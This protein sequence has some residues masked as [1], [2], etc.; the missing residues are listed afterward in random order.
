MSYYSLL[1]LIRDPFVATPDPDLFYRCPHQIENLERLEICIRLR[2]GLN[3]VLGPVGTGKSTLSRHFMRILADSPEFTTVLM[4]DPLFENEREFLTWLNREFEIPDEQITNSIWQLKDNLKNK[5]FALGVE[6]NRTVC[7]VI[8]EGQ[9]ITPECME[10]LRELLNYET[11]ES[12]LLQI[13]IFAQDEF[14]ER[15]DAIPNLKD[16]VYEILHLGAFTFRETMQLINTRMDLCKGEGVSR[17]VFTLS[18][19]LAVYLATGG[20]PRKI[21]QLCHK[22]ILAVVG[23]GVSR[24][25]W[26]LVWENT[27]QGCSPLSRNGLDLVLSGTL[28][29]GAGYLLGALSPV[30]EWLPRAFQALATIFRHG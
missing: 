16:R 19:Y 17:P 15:L 22:A 4:L 20:Y 26:G 18:G 24:A 6:Q 2:R 13:V 14:K 12:K 3:V 9:K 25:T 21:I 10:V 28:A 7:L 29:L 1:G 23:Q 30:R 11:N 5:L 8:D 27:E